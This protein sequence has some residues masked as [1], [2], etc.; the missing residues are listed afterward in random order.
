[1][2]DFDGKVAL[3]TGGS[4]GIGRASALLYAQHGAQV[5][6]ADL[7]TDGGSETVQLIQDAG[8][9]AS[10]V[11]TDIS[12]ADSCAAMVQACLDTYGKLDVACNA[13]GIGGYTER[14]VDYPLDEWHK[15]ISI[16]L[17]GVFFSL[18]YEIPAMLANGSGA[19]VNISSILGM[20]STY[21]VAAYSAAKHGVIGLTK[22]AAIENAKLGIRVNAIGPGS[23]DTPMITGILENERAK[24]A[25]IRSHPIGRVGYPEEVAELVIWLTS[26]KASYVTGAYYPVDGGFLAQ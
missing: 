6:V 25:T 23:I 9:T 1:M 21:H 19:I 7:N 12:D 10:F 2:G 24:T 3:V 18:K 13:A 16:N 11:S 22:T 4:S 26:Y 8:G 20:V 5:V 17:S 14:L 15:V